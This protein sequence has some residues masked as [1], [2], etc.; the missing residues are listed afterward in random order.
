MCLNWHKHTIGRPNIINFIFI[1]WTCTFRHAITK[2]TIYIKNTMHTAMIVCISY[3]RCQNVCIQNFAH[4]MSQMWTVVR[5]AISHGSNYENASAYSKPFSF[6]VCLTDW[7]NL[8]DTIFFFFTVI[9]TRLVKKHERTASECSQLETIGKERRREEIVM[10][11]LVLAESCQLG[12]VR[13][14]VPHFHCAHCSI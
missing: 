12:P 1:L 4:I 11:Q 8:S 5:S 6:I 13:P 3:T 9:H 2:V 14:M 7:K 10:I